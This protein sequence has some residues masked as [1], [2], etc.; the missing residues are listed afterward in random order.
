MRVFFDALFLV[1]LLGKSCHVE[2]ARQNTMILQRS[3]DDGSITANLNKT[4][5]TDATEEPCVFDGGELVISHPMDLN[6]SDRFFTICNLFQKG[7]ELMVDYINSAPRCGIK[8]QGKN[9]GVVLRSYAEDTSKE[10]AEAIAL[11]AEPTTDFFLAPYTSSISEVSS[12]TGFLQSVL[13]AFSTG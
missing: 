6:P 5:F 7:Y 1:S 9:Y 2:A 8:V 13:L 10:K 11:A 12:T 3:A 4:L